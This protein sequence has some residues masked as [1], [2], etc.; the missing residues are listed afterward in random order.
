MKKLIGTI[1]LSLSLSTVSFADKINIFAASSTK[2]AMQEIIENFKSK[3]PNDEIIASY[4][5]TGKAYAQF[6]NGFQYDIF[7]AADTTYPNKIV[8]DKNAI[9][10]PVVYAMGVVALYSN[11]KELIKKGIEALKDDK[12]KHISIANPKLAPYGVAATEILENYDLLDIVKNKIVLG[13]NIAQSV[14]FV[15]SGAAEI[16]L[17]AFSLIKTIKKEE[18]Y[19]LVDPSKYKPM[20]QSFVLTKYAKEK[21]LATKFASFITSEESKKIFEKYGF[22]I[23]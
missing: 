17:V 14:Q 9:A 8:S 23:K 11:D 7:M 16:G 21:P 15:D 2:L 19:V 5:A 22:G 12:I 1:V 4:S 6:T 13:D 10:E 20:E 18:E 3:N